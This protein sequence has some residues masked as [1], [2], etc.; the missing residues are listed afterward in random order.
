MPAIRSN[1][2][3]TIDLF[4][5]AEAPCVVALTECGLYLKAMDLLIGMLGNE[6][7]AKYHIQ[8][9]MKGKE[10]PPTEFSKKMKFGKGKKSYAWNWETA[11]RVIIELP[12]SRANQFRSK[13]CVDIIAKHLMPRSWTLQEKTERLSE[14]MASL[15]PVVEGVEKQV[16][17]R[18]QL[19][20]GGEREV[21]CE[22]G[23]V[24]LL[25]DEYIVEVKNIKSW[26]GALGQVLVY[27]NCFPKHK[28]C[29]LL[30]HEI[31]ITNEKKEFITRNCDKYD[32]TLIF[33]KINKQ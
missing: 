5:C 21:E 18:L 22:G 28:K 32:V 4:E 23:F 3:N 30:F 33:K 6:G 9:L 29:I 7:L 17:D 12:G 8:K 25:T 31:E 27:G 24:D 19:E 14:M 10:S 13:Y 2:T 15:D 26:K 20:I 16:V 1:E 11:I